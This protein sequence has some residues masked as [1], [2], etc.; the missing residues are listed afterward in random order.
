MQSMNVLP[1]EDRPS[2]DMRPAGVR[3]EFYM[4]AVLDQGAS[5]AAGRPIYHDVEFVKII[6]PGIVTNVHVKRVGP[7]EAQRWA[8]EYEAFRAGREQP[9]EGT[10]LAEWPILTRAMIK[11]LQHFEIRTVEELA[12]L[13]D[14]A[15]QN[16]GMGG[17]LLRD[18]AKAYLS[19]AEREKLNSRL[20]AQNELQISRIAVLENQVRELGE[21][22][23][24]IDAERRVLADRPHALAT[25]IT[26]SVDPI[27]QFRASQPQ[28]HAPSALDAMADMPLRRPW[29]AP[30]EGLAPPE[31]PPPSLGAGS[32]AA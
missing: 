23:G 29:Q 21:L 13:S 22:L 25:M 32:E 11:E 15:V 28:L 14:I 3:A 4:D 26:G 10:P 18:R 27:E 16:I 30:A 6:I 1:F 17:P 24:R 12:N 9:V 5:I 2:L 8:K 7:V 31:A 19:D 20:A